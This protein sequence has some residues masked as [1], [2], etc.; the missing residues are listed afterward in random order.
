MDKHK[1]LVELIKKRNELC[2]KLDEIDK[3]IMAIAI[4]N[5]NNYKKA[6]D[7]AADNIEKQLDDSPYKWS[8]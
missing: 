5:R 8:K 1:E 7:E 3:K 6:V 2:D 4:E